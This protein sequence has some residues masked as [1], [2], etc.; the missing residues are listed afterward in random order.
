MSLLTFQPNYQVYKLTNYERITHFFNIVLCPKYYIGTFS[1]DRNN[2]RFTALLEHVSYS[3]FIRNTVLYFSRT[4]CQNRYFIVFEKFYTQK[5][6]VK[7]VE[8]PLQGCLEVVPGIN[9]LSAVHL[10]T[11]P[12]EDMTQDLVP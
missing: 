12:G 4:S 11:E 6:D 9:L 10:L 5:S 7:G 8:A 1:T 3:K 2:S